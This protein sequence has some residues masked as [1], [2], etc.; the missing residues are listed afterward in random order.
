M[1][2]LLRKWKVALCDCE[3]SKIYCTYSKKICRLQYKT[4]SCHIQ[5]CINGDQRSQFKS[6][7]IRVR[8]TSSRQIWKHNRTNLQLCTHVGKLQ[9]LQ[10]HTWPDITFAVNQCSWHIHRH[11]NMHVTALIKIHRYLLKT[12]EKGI[13][14]CPSSE[15]AINCS[16]YADL[17]DHDDENCEMSRTGHVLCIL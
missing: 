11:T 9:H 1:Y 12:S 6:N 13:I 16:V 7:T 8:C 2:E 3:L 14:F 15:M 10:G 17:Q 4:E 5:Y